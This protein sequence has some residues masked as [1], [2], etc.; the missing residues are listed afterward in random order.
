MLHF[1]RHICPLIA[2]IAFAATSVVAQPVEHRVDVHDHKASPRAAA[3]SATSDGPFYYLYP[4]NLHLT[5]GATSEEPLVIRDQAGNVVSGEVEFHGVDETL[6]SIDEDGYVTALRVE[7]DDEIGNW[8]HATFNGRPVSNTSIVR[9]LSKDY[10]IEFEE[11]VGEN[12]VLYY[13]VQVKDVDVESVVQASQLPTVNEYTYRIQERLMGLRPFNGARQIIE[14]DFGES[15]TSRVCGISGNPFRLG[16]NINAQAAVWRGCFLRFPDTMPMWFVHYHEMGHNFTLPSIMFGQGL[17]SGVGPLYVEGL[18][19][20]MAIETMADI[21]AFPEEFPLRSEVLESIRDEQN[22]FREVVLED[23]QEWIDA[24]APFDQ[25]NAN[26]TDA[27]WHL[28]RDERGPDFGTRFFYPL[29]PGHFEKDGSPLPALLDKIKAAGE[30][31]EHTFFIALM[32]VAAGR[33]LSTR[34]V[35]EYNYPFDPSLFDEA[36]QV[37]LDLLPTP[38]SPARLAPNSPG[39]LDAPIAWPVCPSPSVFV[40]DEDGF[41]VPNAEVTFTVTQGD[42]TVHDA[43]VTTNERGIA[44]VGS[45]LLES[46]GETHTLTATVDGLPNRDVVFTAEALPT[47]DPRLDPSQGC[48]LQPRVGAP[49]SLPLREQTRWCGAYRKI[50]GPDWLTLSE[51]GTLSGTPPTAGRDTVVAQVTTAGRT[52]EIQVPVF[53]ENGI[54]T[55]DTWVR[56]RSGDGSFIEINGFVGSEA[57]DVTPAPLY[58]WGD[59]TSNRSWFPSAHTYTR[60][61]TYTVRI[62]A[63][64]ERGNEAVSCV[65]HTVA[66]TI[67]VELA[68]FNATQQ[69]DHVRLTWQTASET[70]NAGF[71]VQRR[72]GSASSFEQ[73]GFVEGAGTT[74]NPQS[75]HFTD[76]SLPFQTEQLTY[77]LKQVDVGGAFEFSPEVKVTLGAPE[78]LALH[79]AFPNPVRDQVTLRYELPDSGPMQLTVYNTLGQRVATLVRGTQEAGRKEISFNVGRLASGL[80]F[81]RLQADGQA[82]TRKLT[83]VR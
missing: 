16:W 37:A 21:L 4:Y 12:T 52:A 46:T 49:F 40:S 29:H 79:A 71:E 32:S 54:V 72:T 77:R 38:G 50:E 6:I 42:G 73:I 20:A 64:D 59:G 23:F 33:D 34:F 11:I 41:G 22:W 10:G 13:P 53:V 5:P 80:Y 17:G 61:G 62:T 18:A 7:R 2:L 15:E 51:D 76:R 68:T 63:A 9:V 56:S 26:I 60:A 25:I 58:D 47:D 65:D 39:S 66:E 31:G 24:G 57:G 45:W 8:V 28:Y 1:S 36:Y 44:R 74:S 19:S 83:V 48:P 35:D 55:L 75:Y 3:T 27:M 78:Q 69:D 43:T 70:N 67:P 82:L 14:V 81:V 30:T